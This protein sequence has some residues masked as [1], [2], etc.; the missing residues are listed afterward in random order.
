MTI[1]AEGAP[2]AL[3]HCTSM[4]PTPYDTGPTGRD[5]G[6]GGGPFPGRPGGPLGPLAQT[7][8]TCLGAVALGASILEKH[9]KPFRAN[10]PG[11][12]T[13]I[14]IEPGELRDPGRGIEGGVAGRAAGARLA[15][16]RSSRSS[17]S[18]MRPCVTTSPIKAG[19]GVQRGQHLGQAP[20]HRPDPGR[21]WTRSWAARRPG[22]F[23]PTWHVHPGDIGRVRSRH[24]RNPYEYSGYAPPVRPKRRLLDRAAPMAGAAGAGIRLAASPQVLGLAA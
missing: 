5:H 6:S 1:E 7:S 11:P 14:S 3:L 8:G 20:W 16:N 23:R 12:D 2:L 15:S 22:T 4:Y 9:F 13:G 18:P 21:P 17:T 24:C 19:G 10:W